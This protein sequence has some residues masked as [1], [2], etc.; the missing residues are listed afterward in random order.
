[1]TRR[2]YGFGNF[3]AKCTI[4]LGALAVDE[5]F[6]WPGSV[7]FPV[8]DKA[9]WRTLGMQDIRQAFMYDNSR[10][11]LRPLLYSCQGCLLGIPFGLCSKLL[12]MCVVV[13]SR[14][15]VL[16]RGLRWAFS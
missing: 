6:M 13:V 14:F 16:R 11:V 3:D 2:R 10:R 15:G 4:V 1:M 9:A 5:S 12:L 8:A 7:R